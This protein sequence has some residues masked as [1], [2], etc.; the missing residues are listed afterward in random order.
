MI[1]TPS[2]TQASNVQIT[3][4]FERV[5]VIN[6]PERTD[7]RQQIERELAQAGMPL[8]PQ[9]VE[10]FA[11]IRPDHAADFP[12]IGARGCFMSHLAVLRQA[13]HD[14]LANVL[15]LE[16]DLAIA[17]QFRT[18]QGQL[19]QQ[20]QA[21]PWA[22]VYFGHGKKFPAAST[23]SLQPFSGLLTLAHFYGVNSPIFD[24]LINFLEAILRRP[25]GHPEGGPMHVDGA[26]STFRL[27]YPNVPTLIA[28]PSLGWQRSSRSDI[29][30]K[31]FD[32]LP[33]LR[34]VGQITRSG[35]VAI[36][37]VLGSSQLE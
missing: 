37:R 3:D 21:T 35:K 7:R 11:A 34:Q 24:L 28:N 8:K 16:D 29:S 23:A 14:R 20:L 18:Q 22:F 6:L 15:I 9:Q 10:L 12:S 17:P 5:H 33:G 2:G 13:R 1:Q 31:W 4:F 30:P 32:R 36:K 27:R 25:A 19:I 26:F